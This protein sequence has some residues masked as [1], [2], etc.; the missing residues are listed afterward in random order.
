MKVA[1]IGGKTSTI[2][3]KAVGMEPYIAV[4]PEEGPR[5]WESIPLERYGVVIITEPVYRVLLEKVPGFPPQGGLP[6]ILVIPAVSG[7][8]G[9]GIEAIK[10][11]VERAVGAD[12]EG[13]QRH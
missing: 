1:M 12:I 11:K 10:K 8:Q 9:M 3:F 6:V 2:G 13:E 5:I 4:V 7:S